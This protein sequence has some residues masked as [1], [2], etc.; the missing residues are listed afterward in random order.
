M[1]STHNKVPAV[2]RDS[3][4]VGSKVEAIANA[5]RP[6]VRMAP[7]RRSQNE[8]GF[9][10]FYIEACSFRSSVSGESHHALFRELG[11]TEFCQSAMS[12]R[13][14]G[15]VARQPCFER[16]TANSRSRIAQF[17]WS[18][19]FRLFAFRLEENNRHA[20]PLE[21]IEIA[22]EFGKER[23]V[24]IGE[25]Q[26]DKL[27]GF[28]VNYS[29][30]VRSFGRPVISP[31][32]MAAKDVLGPLVPL[33]ADQ[34]HRR[35]MQ[36]ASGFESLMQGVRFFARCWTC[37]ALAVVKFDAPEWILFRYNFGV[38]PLDRVPGPRHPDNAYVSLPNATFDA[39]S[40][41]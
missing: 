2:A 11:I 33:K 4:A 9:G 24:L 10:P 25:W 23:P 31:S 1:L 17:E 40:F 3:G 15:K 27:T 35:E 16:S 38:E 12:T 41:L 19:G 8:L 29:N 26:P 36:L 30:S 21:F 7:L 20:Q 37:R 18:C 28:V 34:R 13:S 6:K 22:R 14:K 39:L 5:A 32:K